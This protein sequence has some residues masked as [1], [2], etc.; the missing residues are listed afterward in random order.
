MDNKRESRGRQFGRR[1]HRCAVG[2]VGVA[3]STGSSSIACSRGVSRE[4]GRARRLR[5]SHPVGRPVTKVQACMRCSTRVQ[6]RTS[7]SA[8][9][10]PSEGSEVRRA[11]RRAVGVPHSTAEAGEPTHDLPPVWW[12]PPER[13]QWCPRGIRCPNANDE[14]SRQSRK[15]RQCAW[16]NSWAVSPRLRAIST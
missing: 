16:P 6:E 3:V 7:R 4:P 9:V 12:T 5:Q 13:A 1:Q 14:H 2:I 10:S 11:G 15:R 8:T